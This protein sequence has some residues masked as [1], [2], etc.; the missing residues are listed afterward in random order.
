VRLS[1]IHRFS[2]PPQSFLHVIFGF[3]LVKN[4]RIVDSYIEA[5]T[6]NYF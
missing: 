2:F 3:L 5:R 4:T 1:R 6:N